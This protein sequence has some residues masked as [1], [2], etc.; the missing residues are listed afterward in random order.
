MSHLIWVLRGFCCKMCWCTV[1]PIVGTWWAHVGLLIWLASA[2]MMSPEPFIDVTVPSRASPYAQRTPLRRT[3]QTQRRQQQQQQQQQHV[4]TTDAAAAVVESSLIQG[5]CSCVRI[6]TWLWACTGSA[7]PLLAW[8][9]K[10]SQ[11]AQQ[12]VSAC[13]LR[14]SCKLINISVP[15]GFQLT[16]V[17]K[18]MCWWQGL[19]EQQI[20][21]CYLTQYTL[22]ASGMLCTPDMADIHCLQIW[23][24]RWRFIW[25]GPARQWSRHGGYDSVRREPY[26]PCPKVCFAKFAQFE[27]MLTWSKW[28]GYAQLL[29][30]RR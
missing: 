15:N 29:I 7:S 13:S 11:Q 27:C 1:R 20:L 9:L 30:S 19:T 16:S 3:A 14:W 26:A 22:Q 21:L 17:C 4:D 25:W 5:V 12:D 6:F 2:G 24:R 10:L 8:R 28:A 18:P 23:N